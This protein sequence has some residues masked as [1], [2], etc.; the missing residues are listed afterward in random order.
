MKLLKQ[1]VEFYERVEPFVY[2]QQIDAYELYKRTGWTAEHYNYFKKK[3]AHEM[4]QAEKNLKLILD[5]QHH[6]HLK[7]REALN[8]TVL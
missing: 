3:L 7:E 6:A 2:N 4:H 5:K 1:G 8:N